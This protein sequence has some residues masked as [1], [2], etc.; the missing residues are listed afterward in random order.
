MSDKPLLPLLKYAAR[1]G[2]TR[3][4]AYVA[5]KNKTLPTIQV[6][7]ALMVPVRKADMALGIG[8]DAPTLLHA[9]E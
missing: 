6:G 9:A 5:A 2:M 8:H 4:Q 3:H 7:K 1:V